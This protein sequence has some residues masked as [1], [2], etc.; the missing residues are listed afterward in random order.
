M[1]ITFKVGDRVTRYCAKIGV[2]VREHGEGT[3]EVVL[4]YHRGQN[5]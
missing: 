3:V 2:P 1:D 5:Q 4:D